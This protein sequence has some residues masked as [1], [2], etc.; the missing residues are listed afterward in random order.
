MSESRLI[1]LAIGGNSLITDPKHVSVKAQYQAAQTTAVHI[2][3]LIAAGHRVAIVHGNGPQ[4]GFILR[5]AELARGTLHMVP[6]DS[7]VADTQGAIGYNL[8]MA[9]YN[10]MIIHQVNR[11]VATVVTQVVVDQDDPSF[12]HPSKPIGSFMDQQTAEKHQR[13]DG[14]SVIEDA[15]RGYRRVVPSPLPR[16]IVELPVIRTLMEQ[17]VVVIASGGGGIPIVEHPDG[18]LEGKEAVI[19]KDLAACLLAKE[20]NADLFVIST[21]VKQV[22]LNFGTPEER[23]LDRM[24]VQEARRY[25]SEGHFAPGSMLPKI[26]AALD[27]VSSTGRTGIITDPEH[28]ML[29]IEGSEGTSITPDSYKV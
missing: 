5:R 29:A 15:G 7:C 26:Q 21:A 18:S 24:T 4:V 27:F 10:E 14:W 16:R 1:V 28:L 2:A 25:I 3:Q 9:L 12:D 11:Q 22:C 17:G 6:L 19:D 13:E 23:C 20:L 8:Q